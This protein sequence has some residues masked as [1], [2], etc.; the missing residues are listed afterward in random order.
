MMDNRVVT[1]T[2]R[3][4]SG[5]WRGSRWRT[6]AAARIRPGV[7]AG[8]AV[9]TAAPRPSGGAPGAV[10]DPADGHH[11]ARVLRVVLDLRAQPLDVHV[12]QTGVGAV[13]VPPDIAQQHVA[14]ED[15]P[16]LAGQLRSEEHTS[17]LQSRGHL[18][19]R[20]L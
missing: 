10:A 1:T 12:D 7:G 9:L 8:A 6:S 18:V 11:D 16:G 2:T 20:L 15:L 17:E 5:H 14:G 13:A 3:R 19:S 4:A